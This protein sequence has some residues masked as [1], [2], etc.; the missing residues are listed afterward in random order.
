MCSMPEA[1]TPPPDPV[2]EL[3]DRPEGGGKDGI[4]A[5]LLG[6][7]RVPGEIERGLEP[8]EVLDG[9]PAQAGLDQAGEGDR[10]PLFRDPSPARP[11]QLPLHLRE[12]AL[13]HR[14]HVRQEGRLQEI[15]IHA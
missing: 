3:E 1:S 5:E 4:A 7:P 12:L 10:Q 2:Q 8:A 11:L 9:E 13:A 15:K 14:L 6:L